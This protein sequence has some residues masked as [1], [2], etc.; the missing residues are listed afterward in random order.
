MFLWQIGHKIVLRRAGQIHQPLV[1]SVLAG[2]PRIAG[3]HVC[4]HVNGINR[5]RHGNPVSS[6]ENIQNVPRV[7]LRAVGHENLV[8]L[9]MNSVDLVGFLR[10]RLPQPEITLLRTVA[11]KAFMR[12]KIVNRLVHGLNGG[13]G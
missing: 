9:H 10:N 12:G 11:V 7:A 8:H 4:I 6:A 13:L 3:H 1:G 5:V 2:L